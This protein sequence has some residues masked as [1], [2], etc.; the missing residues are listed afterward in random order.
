MIEILGI[1]EKADGHKY[2]A[3]HDKKWV[4][5]SVSDIFREPEQLLDRVPEEERVNLFFT[6]HNCKGDLP[7][8]F[9]EQWFIPFDIDHVNEDKKEDVFQAF[10]R[11]LKVSD[12]KTLASWSGNG[13]QFFIEL[14]DPIRDE[15]F[16]VYN[17]GTYK[18]IC[19]LVDEELQ[20]C[21]LLGK[22]DPAVFSYKR[23][24]RLPGTWNV[25]K[26]KKKRA[27]VIQKHSEP[28]GWTF[29]KVVEIPGLG[30]SD[31]IS[32]KE[33]ASF[34]KPDVE[35]VLKEC[36]F[37]V[38]AK[39]NP[40][41]LSEEEW[42]AMIGVLAHM[43]GG[44]ELSHEYSKGY[45]GYRERETEL[46]INHAI[47]ASGPRTCENIGTISKKCLD[48]KHYKTRLR[49]PISIKGPDYI[50]SE[51]EGFYKTLLVG[52]K[53]KLVPQYEDLVRYYNKK[54]G[55]TANTASG[56]YV[57]SLEEK[58]WTPK[59]DQL[60][61]SF[62]YGVMSPKPRS[63][64]VEEAYRTLLNYHAVTLDFFDR[65][66]RMVNLQNGVLDLKTRVLQKH[67][68][69]F[70]FRTI[71]TYDYDPQAQCPEFLRFLNE[72]MCGNQ[73]LVKIIQEYM[74]YI[75]S[76]DDCWLHKA[77]I[78]LGHG[79]NGKSTLNQVLLELIGDKNCSKVPLSKFGDP[80]F[81]YQLEGALVNLADENSPDALLN[82]DVFK[83]AVSGGHIN[84]KKLYTQ[85][86][87]V[88][89]RA[90]F[91]FNC[92]SM[93]ISKDK[94]HGLFR[95]MLF[96]PFD[97][98]FTEKDADVFIVK[99]LVQELPGILNFALE[100]Y[101]RL[102]V[103]RKFTQSELSEDILDTFKEAQ[104]DVEEWADSCIR[105]TNSD[106]DFTTNDEMYQHYQEWCEATRRKYQTGEAEFK[107]KMRRFLSGYKLQKDR[108]RVG[109]ARSL[110]RG[111]VGLTIIKEEERF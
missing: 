90:K 59:E 8:E 94:T 61:K 58:K 98:V 23:L 102:V 85:P 111:Y 73:D 88:K 110:R 26:Q 55:K 43:P 74:G 56:L 44:R 64:I 30:S 5:A 49:S 39:E 107:Y 14:E 33:Y 81:L 24:M 13:M 28:Q 48:C 22:C 78:F 40:N 3:F 52:T 84:V 10:C 50:S 92:N 31:Y 89:N 45:N 76:G 18:L 91:I 96:I 101:D 66:K 70:G 62:F 68:P 9:T 16:F 104:N 21:D 42:Y 67:D 17:R 32:R 80:Q 41:A 82:S 15:S 25:K 34:P 77:L 65:S 103:N 2:H 95:R 47:V 19:E 108:R 72:V 109:T 38:H 1:R 63:S 69:D 57:Y 105:V 106:A 6:V 20:K 51:H 27:Y 7:R 35:A 97:R 37:L 100:G 87:P 53:E 36:N 4:A 75:V 86:Y 79:S 71:L 60:I 93:P 83:E 54:T 12:Q 46:K 99:K 29:E 11:V